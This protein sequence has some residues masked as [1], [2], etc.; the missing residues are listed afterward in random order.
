MTKVV[1]GGIIGLLLSSGIAMAQSGDDP[2]IWQ[3]GMTI[4]AL[5]AEC[6]GGGLDGLGV[7]DL[8]AAVYRPRFGST[9]PNAK[10]SALQF[11]WGRA[12]VNY[13]RASGQFKGNSAYSATKLGARAGVVPFSGNLQ[14]F[15]QNPQTVDANTG[16]ID[17]SGK[18]T[19]FQDKGATCTATV[20]VNLSKRPE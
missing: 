3:G 11:V 14:N 4:T 16:N 2:A 6:A 9:G 1:V 18:I 17:L 19:N 8:G 5:T 13:A 12:A 7:G 15:V 20:S 10:P